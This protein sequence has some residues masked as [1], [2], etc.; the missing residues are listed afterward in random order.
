[1]GD[2]AETS[3]SQP[4]ARGPS[5]WDRAAE[6]F[7]AVRTLGLAEQEEA[8]NAA[9]EGNPALLA[10][11]RLML[12]GDQAPLPIEALADDIR[13]LQDGL[14]G[15][16]PAAPI[17]PSAAGSRIGNYHLLERLGEGG[18]G[19]VFLAEQERPVRRRVALKIIKLGMDTTQ[20]VARF[21]AERQALALMDHPCIAKVFDAG[22]TETGRPFFVMEL[23]RG[24]PI[25]EH[26]D[27]K[28]L[29]LRQRL[30]LVMQVC[31]ALHHAHQRGVIH[32][33][34]KPSNVLVTTVEDDKP[35]PKVIDF[36]IAK[37]T[38]ARL[39]ERTIFTEFRQMIGTPE[40]MSPEQ[41][42]ES[43]EDVD[44]RTDVYSAGVLLY[45]LLTGAT[46]FDSNRLRSA[47][48]GEIQRIIREEDPPRPSTRLRSR[49]ETL[50]A[51]AAARAMPPAKLPSAVRGE[52]DWIVMKALEKDRSRRYDSA[53]SMARD[54]HRYLTGEAVHAAPPG[55]AYIASKFV[56][57]HRGKV[58]VAAALGL[59]LVA[60]LVATTLM[61]LRAQA[62]EAEQSR[63]VGVTEEARKSEAAL[64]VVA[65]QRS[66]EAE[67]R[68]YGANIAAAQAALA[69]HDPRTASLRLALC[70]EALRG[71]EWRWLDASREHASVVCRGHSD[72]AHEAVFSPDGK[73]LMTRAREPRAVVFDAATGVKLFELKGVGHEVSAMAFSPDS[74]MIVTSMDPK[75]VT[76]WDARTGDRVRVIDHSF[77]R[78]VA[79]VA[80]SDDGR[81]VIGVG[82]DGQGVL[83]DAA[84]GQVVRSLGRVGPVQRTAAGLRLTARSEKAWTILDD[85]GETVA[86][87]EDQDSLGV[88]CVFHPSGRL[89]GAWDRAGTAS[90]WNAATGEKRCELR[91]HEKMV[92]DLAFS[93]DGT[94]VVTTC[95][96]GIARVWDSADG[97]EISAL[98]G[99]NIGLVRARFSPDG[100]RVLTYGADR[101]ARVWEGGTGG[102][103]AVM[104]GH[105]HELLHA[106]FTLDG[107][108]VVTASRDRTI[109]LWDATSG[110][111]VATWHGAEGFLISCTE[112]PDTT[113]LA[114]TADDGSARVWETAGRA[115]VLAIDLGSEIRSISIVSPRKPAQGTALPEWVVAAVPGRGWEL[116]DGLTGGHLAVPGM[117]C[118]PVMSPDGGEMLAGSMQGPVLLD[119]RT[120]E[121]TAARLPGPEMLAIGVAASADWSRLAAAYSDHSVRVFDRRGLS[122]LAVLRGHTKKVAHTGM[123]ADG[124]RVI[125]ASEDGTARVWD[126]AT[127][128]ELHRLD[129]LKHGAFLFA[130]APDNI[131]VVVG[132]LYHPLHW[133][134][135]QTGE[136]VL[137][138]ARRSDGTPESVYGS[139][140]VAFSTDGKRMISVGQ[141]WAARV[142]DVATGAET[143]VLRGHAGSVNAAAFSPDGTRIVTASWDESLRVWDAATGRE[144][145]VLSGH[146]KPVVGV[147]FTR[148]G[149]RIVSASSDGTVRVWDSVP[150]AVRLRES[151]ARH[152]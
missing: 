123:L 90:V 122:E 14:A 36:G 98:R 110:E 144:V 71:W 128:L 152:R 77:D 76:L 60:G 24:L 119:A 80:F 53:G 59:S 100:A 41:A 12:R 2:D 64:R 18:F 124:S 11:V 47:A 73:K 50:A 51:I 143:L 20:V 118:F 95:A 37:A 39:T 84:S 136:D 105:T 44:T 68:A 15:Q 150:Y 149:T 81:R 108:R 134:N 88:E 75:E 67:Q 29:G 137:L 148:D 79:A 65:D 31:E 48:Y 120:G 112:S 30:G 57:K 111:E 69:L 45:E 133:W 130:V 8:L 27:V 107:T 32:R 121:R 58:A 35:I 132:G 106:M 3:G 91:G 93:A 13:A 38:S 66:V 23:V 63:L 83:F 89:L 115:P 46:P 42:G 7:L 74:S 33:D 145:A 9:C 10:T 113:R 139:I 140:S 17:G 85:R 103:I 131:H 97:R 21:E 26:C 56:R 1:M 28:K 125:T 4:P 43:N 34:I 127:G 146:I 78:W 52:L 114:T 109:R 104:R 82:A 138:R 135:T 61:M 102:L 5:T 117:S 55:R 40:Y 22:A 16:A 72:R 141:D 94:R 62:A 129:G 151:L 147:A 96:N 92:S 70:P 49:A 86:T 116:Y 6:V 25:T 101:T 99:H 54:L 126:A 142:W 19:V 87:P